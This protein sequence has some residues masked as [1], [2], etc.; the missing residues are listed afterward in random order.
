MC[1]HGRFTVRLCYGIGI[2]QIVPARNLLKFFRHFHR[3]S[4]PLAAARFGISG[5]FAYW[6]RREA[7]R[8]RVECVACRAFLLSRS[9]VDLLDGVSG[10]TRREGPRHVKWGGSCINPGYGCNDVTVLGGCSGLERFLGAFM[11]YRKD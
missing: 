7:W 4:Y 5:L 1:F 10:S 2:Q 9:R 3:W 11:T 6:G 8:H